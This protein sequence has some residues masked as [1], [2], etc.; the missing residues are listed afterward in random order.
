MKSL[1]PLLPTGHIPLR[2]LVYRVHAL[3]GSM[4]PLIWDFGQLKPDVERLYT[5]QIVSRYVSNQVR[6]K[7]NIYLG[8][9]EMIFI[10]GDS[11]PYGYIFVTSLKQRF[12]KMA[13]N[14]TG[15]R[16]VSLD[17]M[18][19]YTPLAIAAQIDLRDSNDCE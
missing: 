5:N 17:C 16:G 6:K 15:S 10:S 2:H 3:P 9:K 4:R 8:S 19:S 14:T 12:G 7:D 1:C 13:K 18:T 11:D